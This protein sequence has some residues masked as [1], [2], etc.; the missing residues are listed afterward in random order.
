MI[1]KDLE[2]LV[3]D[4]ADKLF[5]KENLSNMKKLLN[6]LK[7]TQILAF[8]GTFSIQSLTNL[9]AYMPKAIEI[10][11][12]PSN[13][14]DLKRKADTSI[15]SIIDNTENTVI[16]NKKD[17]NLNNIEQYYINL[18]TVDKLYQQKT[19]LLIE[20]LNKL[21]YSIC[22]VF[23]NE[24]GRGEDLASDLKNEGFS[25]TFIHGDQSQSDRIKVMNRL[26]LHKVN[27]IVATDL[28]SRGIDIEGIDLVVNYD[29]PKNIETYFHRIGRTG[30]YGKKGISLIFIS[31]D[32][33]KTEFIEKYKNLL[34][35]REIDKIDEIHQ[36]IKEEKNEKNDSNQIGF[37]YD[38]RIE[39][40]NVDEKILDEDEFKYFDEVNDGNKEIIKEKGPFDCLNCKICKEL[41]LKSDQMIYQKG[42]EILK[43]FHV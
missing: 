33:E 41:L 9:K 14:N 4:E 19:S 40:K 25:V 39:W 13:T 8:S 42:F 34:K 18:I 21:Q 2:S 20:I 31:N 43:Y 29:M 12:I 28:L 24:K 26:S 35:I 10:S 22:L 27:V 37:G 17:L 15:E 30:R 5:S 1:L 11:V 23:Y 3:L 36:A 32:K 38:D 6:F 16:N 7:N